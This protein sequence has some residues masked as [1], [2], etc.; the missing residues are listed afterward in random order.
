M[1]REEILDLIEEKEELMS[2]LE[3]TTKHLGWTLVALVWLLAA[4]FTANV[5]M[6][7]Q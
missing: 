2:K 1:F 7:T 5:Y 4:S 6:V 3:S